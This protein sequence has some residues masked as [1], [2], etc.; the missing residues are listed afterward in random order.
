MNFK[1]RI[2]SQTGAALPLALIALLFLTLLGAM[3]INT[4]S[5]EVRLAG[6][7]R[8]DQQAVYA[9]EAAVAHMRA[10]LKQRLV[11]EGVIVDWSSI[12]RGPEAC[13]P[14]AGADAGSARGISGTIAGYDY[15][16]CAFDDL[17][18]NIGVCGT[19]LAEI[20]NL[21]TLNLKKESDF[22]HAVSS[23]SPPTYDPNQKMYI[24][25]A[26]IRRNTG[27]RSALEVLVEPGGIVLAATDSKAQAG[28]GMYKTY[29]GDDTGAVDT[30][31]G[32][33]DIGDL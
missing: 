22:A 13:N 1:S 20:S 18:A 14:T 27:T 23:G 8:D 3:A 5:V 33:Q 26:A 28:G 10:R 12:L 17:D 7:E 15:N 16:A 11:D 29:S 31:G 9:A 24:C 30:T 21:A 25:A 4:S 32:S 19:W 6:N 2:K